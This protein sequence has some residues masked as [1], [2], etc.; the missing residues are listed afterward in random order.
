MRIID[1][2]AH[3]DGDWLG[4]RM[5]GAHEMTAALARLK[6]EAACVVT[7]AG[8]YGECPRHNDA[9]LER[10]S[11]APDRLIPFVTVDP[12]LG[13]PAIEELERCLVSPRFRGVKFHSWL[14]AFASSMVKPTMI[15][16]LRV[17]ARHNVPVLFHDG[18]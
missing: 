16:I 12:K 7:I 13:H 11:H 2:H 4:M 1:F 17:A 18:T 5:Q 15:E 3:L 10:T 8:F 9:L 6:V 14:Q